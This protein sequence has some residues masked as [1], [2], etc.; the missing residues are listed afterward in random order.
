VIVG[1]RGE[2]AS[3]QPFLD[4]RTRTR[5]E[6]QRAALETVDGKL[7]DEL[8]QPRA[9]FAG[10]ALDTKW[11]RLQLAYFTGYAMWTY[12]NL[13][14]LLARQDVPSEEGNPWK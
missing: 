8:K 12:L 2:W 5:F 3:H 6:P 1:T 10:H 11:T 14:F 13:P 4:A 7:I 9:S